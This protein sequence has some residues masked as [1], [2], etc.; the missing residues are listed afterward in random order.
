[1]TSTKEGGQTRAKYHYRARLL[2]LQN[3]LT[4][5]STMVIDPQL[6]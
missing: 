5:D 6:F 3:K 1:M 4:H 2:L